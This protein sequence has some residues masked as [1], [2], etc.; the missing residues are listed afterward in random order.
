M[1][2]ELTIKTA[3][4]MIYTDYHAKYIT[5]ELTKRYA[6]DNFEKLA[7][8]LVDAQVDLNPHQVGAALFAFHSPLSKGALARLRPTPGFAIR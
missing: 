3:A 4:P 7:G 2:F 6:T 1:H 5:Y 8:A